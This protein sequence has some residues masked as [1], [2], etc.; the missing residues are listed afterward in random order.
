MIRRPPRSTRTDTLL[1]YTALFRS[2]VQW[3]DRG[4]RA[5]GPLL[6]PERVPVDVT[7]RRRPQ[8]QVI[9]R[10]RRVGP[11]KELRHRVVVTLRAVHLAALVHR[12]G[13]T[14]LRA[15]E[16]VDHDVDPELPGVDAG[17]R[18]RPA[19]RG[20]RRSEEHTSELQS[21]MRNSYA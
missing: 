1:P 12:Q 8:L 5:A 19:M 17:V 16:F 4:H 18:A 2:R 15:G 14:S 9:A 13:Q 10:H 20:H 21:L 11:T 7:G 6:V 3:V